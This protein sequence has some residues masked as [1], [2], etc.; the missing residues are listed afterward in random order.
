M[1]IGVEDIENLFFTPSSMTTMLEKDIPLHNLS[2][3][4]QNSL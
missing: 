4:P 3:G 1:Q 2:Y